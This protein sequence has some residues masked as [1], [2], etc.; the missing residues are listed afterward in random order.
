MKSIRSIGFKPLLTVLCGLGAGIINGLLGSIDKFIEAG[1]DLFMSLITNLPAIIIELVKSMPKIISS[2]VSALLN[3]LGSF[4]DVGAN[5]VRGLWEG[6]QGLASWIWDKVS[7]WASDL[8]DGICDFFG[9]HSPSRKM[10]W[11]GDMMME[12]LAGGIDETAGEAI[13]SATHMANDLNSVFDDL[14]ADLSTSLPSDI[15][16]NAHSSLADG[17]SQGGFNLQLNIQNFNNYSS[18]DITELTNEIM[19]TAGAFAQRKG[20]V[21]A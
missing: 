11:I 4:V 10:A 8:W 2:L 12:G 20:V 15:N 7:S 3:G 14:Y 18:E 16:V 9:I 6:I 1:V 13:D 17:T 19:A 21:F 5:L